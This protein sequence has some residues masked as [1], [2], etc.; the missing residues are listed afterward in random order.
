MKRFLLKI[1]NFAYLSKEKTDANQEKIRNV[2]WNAIKK[3]I[4]VNARFLDVGCGAGYAMQKAIDELKCESYGVDPDPGAH[5][6]G[7]YNNVNSQLNIIQ[8]FSEKIP[9]PDNHFDIVYSS[10]VLEHVNDENQS[11]KEMKRVLKPNGTL[12]IGMPTAT[13]AWI[14]LLS[15]WLFT[16]H[17]RFFNVIFKPFPFIKTGKTAFI[18]L[19]IPESHSSNRAKTKLYDLKYYKINN[20]RKIVSTHLKIKKEIKPA[21]Y[22]YPEFIQLFRMKINHRLSS[23]VFFICSNN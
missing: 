16:T 23:S 10:H 15:S 5:G 19:F 22:P 9:F 3:Y 20:W 1:Y 8:A 21:L 11:L 14:G 2:E 17:Q 4:P 13:M 6:V 7:R 18:N 12:I